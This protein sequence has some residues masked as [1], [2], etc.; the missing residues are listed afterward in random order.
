[1]KNG[2]AID[3]ATAHSIMKKNNWE[4]GLIGAGFFAWKV[5]SSLRNH[6]ISSLDS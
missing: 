1:M 3:P 6:S 4:G 2:T 5:R